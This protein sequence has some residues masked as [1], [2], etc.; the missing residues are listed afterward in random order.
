MA[1]G[2]CEA[3]RGLAKVSKDDPRL[4]WI[5]TEHPGLDRWNRWQLAETRASYIAQASG[6][7]KRLLIVVD[8][9]TLAARR[10]AT[11]DRMSKTWTD[12]T[13]A[14]ASELLK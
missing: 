8:K 7:W 5:I 9:E 11:S 13:G 3:C 1:G 6:L 4:V 10:L 14:L 12:A 2:A